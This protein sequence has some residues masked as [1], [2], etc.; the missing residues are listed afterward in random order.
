MAL[1]DY[2][3][4]V[5]RLVRCQD[6][7]LVTSQDVDR[8]IASAVAQLSSD[9]PRL[10][11][12]DVVWD[13]AGYLVDAPADMTA[14]SRI[15]EAEHPIGSNPKELVFL[16]MSVLPPATLTL[17]SDTM[18]GVDDTVRVTFTAPHAL[19][20]GATPVDTIPSAH[21]DALAFYAASLLCRELATHYSGERES[22]IG[23]D[24]SNTDSRARNY[25]MR[26]KEYRAAY[27]AA[28]GLKDPMAASAGAGSSA[29]SQAAQAAGA[30]ASWPRRSRS[31]LVQY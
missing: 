6:A 17:I 26:A 5:P 10:L 28:L 21:S 18:I 31:S 23:A 29:G 8:A 25:A 7:E 13:V 11:V 16:S 9:A 14:D 2:Q 3:Q 22:S 1:A 27:F 19:S 15:V 24:A 20:D 30:V 12:R 4:T